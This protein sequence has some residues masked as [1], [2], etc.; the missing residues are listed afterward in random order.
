MIPKTFLSFAFTE[1][2]KAIGHRKIFTVLSQGDK[3]GTLKTVQT[4]LARKEKM[5]RLNILLTD[6]VEP[7]LFYKQPCH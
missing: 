1:Y 7:G 5:H 3:I 4:R 6:P 2:F